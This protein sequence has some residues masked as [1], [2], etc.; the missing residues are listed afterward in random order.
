MDSP[1]CDIQVVLGG[2][3]T[4]HAEVVSHK[5]DVF[6]C[7]WVPHHSDAL[8]PCIQDIYIYIYIYTCT[9][10]YIERERE[11]ERERERESECIHA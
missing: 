6:R 10:I 11:S 5:E 7:P 1:V 4:D 8:Y 9:Y 2:V 3:A